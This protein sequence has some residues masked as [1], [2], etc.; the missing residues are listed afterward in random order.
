[1]SKRKI[2]IAPRTL[3]AEEELK[4]LRRSF[5]K[6]IEARTEL[7]LGSLVRRYGREGAAKR[8]SEVIVASI[9]NATKTGLSALPDV[10]NGSVSSD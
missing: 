2:V 9:Q 1:M 10:P 8:I 7:D 3:T 6:V 4:L 5:S